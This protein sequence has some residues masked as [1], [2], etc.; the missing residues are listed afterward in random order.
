MSAG[1]SGPSLFLV[2]F[3]LPERP[4]PALSPESRTVPTRISTTSEPH[5][6]AALLAW[7]CWLIRFE[8]N[9]TAH[10]SVCLMA[11]FYTPLFFLGG[12]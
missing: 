4:P 11:L 2:F 3:Y 1:R 10:N 12:V 8:C 5:Y 9:F 7:N 6:E